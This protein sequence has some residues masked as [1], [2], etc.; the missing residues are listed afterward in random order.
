MARNDQRG[1]ELKIRAKMDSWMNG[2]IDENEK[3]LSD[4]PQYPNILQNARKAKP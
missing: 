4:K 2:W 3:A 1:F